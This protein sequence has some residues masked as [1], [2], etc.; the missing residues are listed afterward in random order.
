M[1]RRNINVIT[2]NIIIKWNW[3]VTCPAEIIP[4]RFL[5][6]FIYSAFAYVYLLVYLFVSSLILL[7][8]CLFVPWE[9]VLLEKLGGGVRPPS[10]NLYPIYDQNLRHSLPY[11]WPDQKIWNPIYGPTLIS[12]TC[13]RPAL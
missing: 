5:L 4:V 13:F 12:K 3:V 1:I 10:Q 7:F 2:N 11:L 8:I 6:S 9:G